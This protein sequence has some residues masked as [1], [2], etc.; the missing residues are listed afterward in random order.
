MDGDVETHKF[1]EVVVLKSKLIGEVCAI[2]ECAVSSWD[3]GVVAVLVVE[4]NGCNPG[5]LCADVKSILESRLPV[6]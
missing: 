2:V 3:L 5:D 1:P 6:L 4:N